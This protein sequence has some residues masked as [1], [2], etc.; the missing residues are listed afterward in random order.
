MCA[1]LEIASTPSPGSENRLA[2]GM[3]GDQYT[4]TLTATGGSGGYQWSL[5]NPDAMPAG[6]QLDPKTG[7][8]SGKPLP[9]AEGTANITVQVTDA[10]GAT[11]SKVYSLTVNPAL[12][13]SKDTYRE[14]PDRIRLEARGGSQPYKWETV[15]GTVLPPGVRLDPDQGT[16]S[17]SGS[18][19]GAG[20][21]QIA[22]RVTDGAD[23]PHSD[24]AS[25]TIRVRPAA[26]RLHHRLDILGI[27]VRSPGVFRLVKH[28]TA[29]LAILAIGV[30][31]A[32]II[33]V[34]IYAFT[35]T[36]QHGTYL[37]V[38]LLTALAAMVAGCLTGFLFG[39]PK[40]VSSGVARQQTSYAPSSNLA[41]V[42]DWLTKLLLGAGLVQLTHLGAPIGDLID[43]VAAGLYAPGAPS[44]AAKV[45][46]GAII[47]GYTAIGLL[48]GYVVTTM[49]YQ[50]RLDSL[51]L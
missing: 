34:V 29:W 42:S 40:V 36:G 11:A 33:P 32:G 18:P 23:E 43:H 15:G 41:E 4:T 45:T 30:P 50:K 46:A 22:V 21:T 47:F 24:D 16:I 17:I 19:A 3:V 13:I 9:A 26:L 51:N 7:T 37:A 28:M 35:T 39:I 27:K 25:F 5:T 2:A 1:A 6:L 38:G 8:I 10:S 48:D 20:T 49:W 12:R 31:I 14:G 44:G